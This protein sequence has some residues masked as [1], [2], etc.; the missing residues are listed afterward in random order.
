MRRFAPVFVLAVLSTWI[1]EVLFG[2]TPLSRIG[3]LVLVAPLYG[4]GAVLIRELARRRG[5]GWWRI[6]LLAV[7]YGI[8]EEGLAIQSFFNPDLFN[9][10]ILGG[11]W[12]G[13]NWVWT[14][15]TLGYDV[16]W[17][18]SVPILLAELLFQ[19]RSAEPWLGR[20]GMLVAS[21]LYVLSAAALAA[22][23]RNFVAPGFSAAPAQLAL[24]V[25][26]AV[27]A[28][29]VALMWPARAAVVEAPGGPALA[30]PAWQVG[31]LTALVCVGWFTLLDLPHALRAGPL[32][33]VPMAALAAMAA[34]FAWLLRRWSAATGWSGLHRAALAAGALLVSA[35]VGFFAVTA[36]NPVDQLGQAG[37][38][39]L[40]AVF[41]VLLVGRLRRGRAEQSGHAAIIAS[42]R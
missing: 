13:V 7:A 1:G 5:T 4:G 33:L 35:L 42:R 26:A 34:L 19:E 25:L 20:R 22:V 31:A 32:V 15:W 36:G 18:I 16:L 17:S 29:T 3:G 39:V 21:T 12:L 30:P 41:L 11:R 10:G 24:A 14:Q 40:T 23:F 2:A 9:A 28:A 37:A 38:A 8:I 27:V 6:V